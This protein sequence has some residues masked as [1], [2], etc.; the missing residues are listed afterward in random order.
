MTFFYGFLVLKASICVLV[1]PH[2]V[3]IYLYRS[4]SAVS[5][6]RFHTL[7][8]FFRFTALRVHAVRWISLSHSIW[9][10]SFHHGPHVVT[11]SFSCKTCVLVSDMV[12]S[13][14][15]FLHLSTLHVSTLIFL[16]STRIF[17]YSFSLLPR[18]F[19]FFLMKYVFCTC[20]WKFDFNFCHRLTWSK[21]YIFLHSKI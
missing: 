11:P 15:R 6:I 18:L 9:L 13:A 10:R 7:L 14:M 8:R 12:W 19:T 21:S 16:W 1:F 17:F 3:C 4:R 5:S 2:I 20:I